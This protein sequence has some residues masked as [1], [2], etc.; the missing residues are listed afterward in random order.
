MEHDTQK[1][2]K[3]IYNDINFIS[4]MYLTGGVSIKAINQETIFQSFR[5]V[6]IALDILEKR[7]LECPKGKNLEK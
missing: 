5:D 7:V 6:R 4:S 1:I 3:E 2:L